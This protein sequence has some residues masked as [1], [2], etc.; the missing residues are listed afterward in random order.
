VRVAAAAVGRA[1]DAGDGVRDGATFERCPL[2]FPDALERADRVADATAGPL[3][4]TRIDGG[5]WEITHQVTRSNDRALVVGDITVRVYQDV[6]YRCSTP[7]CDVTLKTDDPNTIDVPRPA[8]FT[9]RNGDYVS[10]ETQPAIGRCEAPDGTVI[11]NAY[12]VTITTTLRVAKVGIRNGVTLATQLVG[13]QVRRGT[14]TRSAAAHDCNAWTAELSST[15]QRNVTPG[16]ATTVRS[17]NWAGYVVGGHGERITEVRGSWAQP[18]I[19]CTDAKLQ[20]S[21]FWIGIDGSGNDTLEQ[22]GTEADCRS[23]RPSYAAWWETIPEPQT[24]VGLVVRPGDEM[25]A[26]IR[27]AGDRYVMSL[28]N[29]TTA[30]GFTKTVN[31]PTGEGATAEWIAEATSLCRL[32]VCDVQILPDFGAVHFSDAAA[33]TEAS[34]LLAPTDPSWDLQRDVMITRGGRTKAEVSPLAASGEAFTVTW[35]LLS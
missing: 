24:P 20:F 17:R 28:R 19:R 14:P 13:N 32:E 21:S 15:G 1:A 22:I 6:S 7:P 29:R 16:Q 2:S 4:M 27:S 10:A 31:W 23:G 18:A 9:W 30:L 11:A 34:G 12:D 25:T 3:L 35:R 33:G 26:T 5:D 8:T